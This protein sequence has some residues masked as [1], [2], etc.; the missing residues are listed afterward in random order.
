MGIISRSP[1]ISSAAWPSTPRNATC[2]D[3]R[4]EAMSPSCNPTQSRS[5]NHP[6]ETLARSRLGD[7]P[8]PSTSVT[9]RHDDGPTD[10][11][12]GVSS[13]PQT[14]AGPVARSR[15]YTRARPQGGKR[16]RAE[17]STAPRL[18]RSS[19]NKPGGGGRG[20]QAPSGLCKLTPKG[21]PGIPFHWKI[22]ALAPPW[23]T[24]RRAQGRVPPAA[25]GGS[26]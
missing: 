18:A 17:T 13:H 7:A 12:A 5:M 21:Q 1:R 24:G 25:G 10:V 4:T 8:V 16:Q 19:R 15:N 22:Y 23:K 2:A 26:V 6:R 9:E 3:S 11:E 20:G 14:P